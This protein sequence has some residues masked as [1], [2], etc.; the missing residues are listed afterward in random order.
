MTD[1]EVHEIYKALDEFKT[2]VGTRLEAVM[3][4]LTQIEI[5]STPPCKFVEKLTTT[6]DAH[7][8]EH[9]ETRKKVWDVLM[10]FL[11]PAA[12]IA[13]AYAIWKTHAP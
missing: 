11:S 3:V 4:K 1:N 8:I 2:H 12:L 5:N 7:I 13:A 6:L 9:K 10:P